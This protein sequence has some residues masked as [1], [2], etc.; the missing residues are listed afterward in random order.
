VGSLPL[1]SGE[2][3]QGLTL[4]DVALLQ[5]CGVT[6]R[7]A[8]TPLPASG[9]GGAVEQLSMLSLP[10]DPSLLPH[11]PPSPYNRHPAVRASVGQ[12]LRVTLSGTN[13]AEAGGEELVVEVTAVCSLVR[14]VGAAAG[15]GPSSSGGMEG[16]RMG[17]PQV[18]V[19][20]GSR[21]LVAVW[22]GQHAGRRGCLWGGGSWE[23][24]MELF[25]AFHQQLN[26]MAVSSLQP[27]I[28]PT[29]HISC[30]RRPDPAAAPRRELNAGTGTLPPRPRHVSHRF[31]AHA[32]ATHPASAAARGGRARAPA[33]R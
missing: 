4:A 21:E 5:R 31:A 9:I 33:C 22:T 1:A 3:Y 12:A 15:V 30:L 16:G 18:E 29:T 13:Q 27:P 14:G 8:A 2:V 25:A 26:D 32:G 23:L 7:L 19:Q 6:L 24:G 17:T 20:G 11:V 10:A 28:L